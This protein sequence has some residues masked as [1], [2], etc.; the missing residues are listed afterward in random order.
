MKH[1]NLAAGLSAVLPG[2]G[3]AYA[4]RAY[5]GFR[6][7]V[8]EGLLIFTIYQLADDDLWGATYLVAGITLPFYVGNI[9]GA[10]R[11]AEHHNAS[12]R[13]KYVSESLEETAMDR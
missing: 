4:G 3:Q 7:L 12:S 11:S 6:H 9:V 10:K 1:P 5:D 8:F 2:S 13:A